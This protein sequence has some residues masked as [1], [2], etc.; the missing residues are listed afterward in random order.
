MSID[1]APLI[2]IDSESSK[3]LDDAF[4]VFASS[5]GG[6]DVR[7]AIANPLEHVPIGSKQDLAAQALGATVY[8]RDFALRP[9]LHEK[10]STNLASLVQGRERQAIVFNMRLAP[11]LDVVDFD[12]DLKLIRVEER[13]SYKSIPDVLETKGHSAHQVVST[14]VRLSSA[15]LR[16]RRESGALAL[17][18]M[19]RMLMTTE[20]GHIVRAPSREAMIGNIVIQEL[21]ILTNSQVGQ[22]MVRKGLPGVFRNHR[23]TA[24]APRAHDLAQTIESWMDAGTVSAQQ[25]QD[26]FNAIVGRA[27]YEATVTGHYGLS[28]PVYLHITSP[29]RRYADLVN[30]RQLS[31]HVKEE[32]LP[33]D[34]AQLEALTSDL[35]QVL[36]QQRT[37]REES[38]KRKVAESAERQLAA[39]D[40]EAMEENQLSAAIKMV[41]EAGAFPALLEDELVRRATLDILPAAIATRLI[42]QL[43]LPFLSER[44][45]LTLRDWLASTPAR[46]AAMVNSAVQLQAITEAPG[47]VVQDPQTMVFTAHAEL[48]LENG[49]LH[50]GTGRGAQKRQ[51][52]QLAQ[53]QA[54]CSILGVPDAVPAA[55]PSIDASS[56]SEANTKGA[57][58]EWCQKAKIAAPVFKNT[59]EGAAH[60]PAFGASVTIVYQ[61]KTYAATATG[62]GSKRLAEQQ[63]AQSL[64]NQLGQVKPGRTSKPDVLATAKAA[65][66][67]PVSQLTIW[68]QKQKDAAVTY[69]F[70]AL[71]GNTPAFRCTV[72][73]RLGEEHWLAEA[74]G[75]SKQQAKTAGAAAVLDLM[76]H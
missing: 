22:Y 58:L 26:Q 7:V 72:D 61:G 33:Y 73:V 43:P 36:D 14:A 12:L 76:T 65:A 52:I 67:N 2:T 6:F 74:D 32:P 27:R 21:M 9:M 24:A 18:D 50:T 68:S 3:D 34:S 64:L 60:C 44:L 38:Y 42:F 54:L 20:D 53:V 40:L 25:V 41:V 69:A 57:L 45:R 37:D 4:S 16:K 63:A 59:S 70:V 55:V 10:I 29:L 30:L 5:D 17:Y 39:G 49:S 66:E 48:R 8:V 71:P 62:A 35:N 1:R 56:P 51:A 75:T 23:R 46:A 28:L 19:A 47:E 31:A 15:L 11:G 13:L